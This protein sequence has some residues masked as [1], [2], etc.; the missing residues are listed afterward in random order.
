MGKRKS[1]CD[2]EVKGD[3]IGAIVT[4]VSAKDQRGYPSGKCQVT[5][6]GPAKGFSGLLQHPFDALL[7]ALLFGELMKRKDHPALKQMVPTVSQAIFRVN[8]DAGLTAQVNFAV[9]VWP[10]R[11]RADVPIPPTLTCVEDDVA[12]Q[13]VPQ[14]S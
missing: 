6:R 9:A 4:T 12:P 13:T 5:D 8:S 14:L 11:V 1:T 2:V 10:T 7:D 3:E